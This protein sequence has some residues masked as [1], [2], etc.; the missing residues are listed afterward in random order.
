MGATRWF[1]WVCGIGLIAIIPV[2]YLGYK[3]TLDSRWFGYPLSVSVLAWSTAHLT[4]PL[5]VPF[6]SPLNL[7]R[8]TLLG[9]LLLLLLAFAFAPVSGAM[10]VCKAAVCDFAVVYA[11][12][13]TVGYLNYIRQVRD[14]H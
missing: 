10:T 3:A 14:I 11:V 7:E 13:Q 5:I 2:Q 6:E 1:H 9:G 4:S 8:V 12:M